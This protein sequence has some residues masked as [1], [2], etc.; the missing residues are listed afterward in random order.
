MIMCVLYLLLPEFRVKATARLKLA[1]A[2][3]DFPLWSLSLPACLAD[4]DADLSNAWQWTFNWD[5]F[6][7]FTLLNH[8]IC[9]FPFSLSRAPTPSASLHLGVL[10][11]H[12]PP[13][14]FSSEALPTMIPYI[15]ITYL[16]YLKS[17]A[18]SMT[19]PIRARK[20]RKAK[21]CIVNSELLEIRCHAACL[22]NHVEQLWIAAILLGL[23]KDGP[24]FGAK[25]KNLKDLGFWRLQLLQLPAP[26]STSPGHFTKKETRRELH[27][28]EFLHLLSSSQR[29]AFQAV[30][31]MPNSS[32]ACFLAVSWMQLRENP[33]IYVEQL[34]NHS[35]GTLHNRSWV[36]N[37]FIISLFSTL[38]FENAQAV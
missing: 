32:S 21:H 7:E 16:T 13:T 6:H 36:L 15:P 24:R 18:F 11:L 31:C 12:G 19:K 14:I 33:R 9:R 5:R 8:W 27:L 1:E 26:S 35:D 37:G 3:G 4:A 17:A 10:L 25:K 2:P 20:I 29:N 38:L 30:L 34:P 23:N 22:T 28:S